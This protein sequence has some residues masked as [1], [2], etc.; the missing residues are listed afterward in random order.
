M[1]FFFFID[2][3]YFKHVRPLLNSL[4]FLGTKRPVLFVQELSGA[5]PPTTKTRNSPSQPNIIRDIPD[6][7]FHLVFRLIHTD[8]HFSHIK[9]HERL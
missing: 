4:L 7:R 8:G 3:F 2:Y 1:S 6:R 5:S 9:E